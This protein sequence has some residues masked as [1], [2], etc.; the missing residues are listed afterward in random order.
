MELKL[1]RETFTEK[2]TIGSL[3]V[4][5]IFF[6]YTLE[7]KDR[8]LEPG[9]VKEYAKTAIPRGKYKV[10]LSFSNRFKKYLPE[11]IN[12]PQFAGIRIHPGNTAD[13]S[14]GCILV[15]STKAA[16]FIGNSKVTFDKLMKVIQRVEK[17]E[18]INISIE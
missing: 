3:Y 14:E 4:N 15:G 17:I 1:I 9:G 13:H 11:L 6:C 18:K 12:V 8:K 2:S 7:D 10:V 16:D 5:G